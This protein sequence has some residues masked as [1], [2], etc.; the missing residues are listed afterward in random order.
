[1]TQQEEHESTVE[2]LAE[3]KAQELWTTERFL[4][5]SQRF[6]HAGSWA[7]NVVTG[8]TAWSR[9]TYQILG[10]DPESNLATRAAFLE[11]V[12]PEDRHLLPTAETVEATFR[13]HAGIEF[14]YRIVLPDGSLK[15]L[16]SIGHAIRD[17]GGEIIELAGT[18]IDVTER[19]M[20]EIA[21]RRNQDLL[22]QGQSISHTGSW[23][24]N[25]NT[26]EVI[27]TEEHFR[28]FGF[29]PATDQAS[30]QLFR[31]RIHPDDRARVDQIARLAVREARDI[32][33]EY[34]LVF[35]DGS[36][37]YL[38]SV[39]RVGSN[40]WGE[41][42]FV[43]TV[44]DVT[45]RKQAEFDLRRNETFLEEAQRL[46]HTGSWVFNVKTRQNTYWSREENRIFGFDPEKGAPS[47]DEA[48]NRIHETDRPRVDAAV[49]SAVKERK[50]FEVDFRIVLPDGA[51]KHIHSVGYPV[52]DASG[53]VEEL[54]GSSMDLTAQHEAKA[55]LQDAYQQ[56]QD[57][58][59]QLYKENLALR[60]EI[61]HASNPEEIVGTSPAI[62]RV[63]AVVSKVAPI[64]TTVLIVGE[65]GTGKELIAHAIHRQSKRRDK[66]FVR[67]NCAAMPPGL[68]ASELFGHEKG[69]F[70]G[71][72]QQ[73]PGRFEV[74]DGGTLFLDEIGE[75]SAETQTA[76]LRVLQEREFERVGGNRPIR[77]DVRVLAATNRNL[78]A[79]V[80]NGSFRPDLYYRIHVFPIELPPLRQRTED[81]R[82]LVEYF[83]DLYAR[84][85]G[86]RIRGIDPRAMTLLQS[87]SWPGNIR[88]LQN[89]VE[90]AVILAENGVVAVN[91]TW[92]R[93]LPINTSETLNPLTQALTEREKVI[94]ETALAESGGRVSGPNGAS[95][96]LGIPRSTLETKIKS[97]KINKNRFKDF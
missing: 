79:A 53:E 59:D 23:Y 40:S 92:L 8:E 51:V 13:E 32:D 11:R 58:K 82:L 15:Y 45:E 70:T 18:V 88:E 69:A 12:H 20:S 9:E 86:K 31:E 71:A 48:R 24:W 97:L 94:I 91:E 63:L 21:L 76:L 93:R 67:V 60:E 35:P 74:A 80:A 10:Y 50:D 95:A 5:E 75:L 29:D 55:A 37:K 68:I 49:E 33:N 85:I 26:G 64:S 73:R 87:Y 77:V 57:L 7:W 22:A 19:T 14:R 1:M 6:C 62:K 16:H 3:G 52:L 28:I 43:G 54:V 2:T 66:P 30:Y 61:E 96:K 89:I 83:T 72:L 39:G 44:M 78:E 84:R 4:A 42:E 47:F 25:A 27:W 46:S 81:I 38:H 34:R 56:I 36:M 17:E 90:R 65:T 41:I